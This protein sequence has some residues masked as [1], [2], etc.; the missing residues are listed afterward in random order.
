MLKYYAAAAALKAF[1]C[2]ALTRRLY[3]ALGNVVGGRKRATG[4]LPANYPA[5]LRRMRET[6]ERN[7]VLKDGG[8]VLEVGTGWFHWEAIATHLFYGTSG[9]LFDVWDNR[10]FDALQNYFGQL[11]RMADS[12][13][14]DERSLSRARSALAKIK[15]SSSWEELYGALGFEYTINETGMLGELADGSFDLV[16]SAGVLE[17][18]D[19][20][21]AEGVA[22]G[23]AGALKPGGYAFNSINIRDHLQQYDRSVSEKNYLRYSDRVWNTALN[24][25]VQY[26]N[27]IQRKEWLRL[28]ENAGLELLEEDVQTVDIS[29]VPV[30]GPFRSCD[31]RDLECGGLVLLHRKPL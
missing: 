3:R 4:K 1:S 2:N 26:I 23:I 9:V 28:F 16:I 6:F 17:H 5:R 24:N 14:L 22:K 11:D 7:G 13:G 19:A 8:R 25:R 31:R 27:R 20:G 18:V 29:G 30:A 12:L 21:I 15:A 10:Q